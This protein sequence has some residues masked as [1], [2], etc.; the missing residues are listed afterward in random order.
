MGDDMPWQMTLIRS[1][2]APYT[3]ID[4][5]F[6]TGPC[7]DPIVTLGS[8]QISD[9]IETQGCKSREDAAS[10]LF[11]ELWAY[12]RDKPPTDYMIYLRKKP[13]IESIY[14]GRERRFSSRCRLL[15]T[16]FPKPRETEI[17][18]S[19]TERALK[20][21]AFS[22]KDSNGLDIGACVICGMTIE[23]V[24]DFAVPC[25]KQQMTTEELESWKKDH[26]M[27][28]RIY[29]AKVEEIYRLNGVDE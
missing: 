25:P 5:V 7:G 23:F 15:A 14:R 6:G 1:L 29:K 8:S 26:S 16:R 9:S 24:E 2:L 3:K 4:W 19:P 10:A 27:A 17:V 22:A 28:Y 21:H 13:T 20:T 12:L 11:E 18:E